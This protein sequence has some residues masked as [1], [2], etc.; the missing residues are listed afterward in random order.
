MP[1]GI[2][3]WEAEEL[4]REVGWVDPQ[5][6]YQSLLNEFTQQRALLR[7]TLVTMKHA[8]VFITS[9]EKMHPTGVGLYDELVE[10]I[11]AALS[12]S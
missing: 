4:R 9:R 1:F 3:E 12:R 6:K 8:H 7:E 2:T 10:Q 5:I 11:D